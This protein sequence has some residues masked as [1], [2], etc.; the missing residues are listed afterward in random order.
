MHRNREESRERYPASKLLRSFEQ[1]LADDSIR[2][3]VVNTPV[4]THF[5]FCK[6]ALN[7]G[8]AVVVEKPFTVTLDEAK[9]LAAISKSVNPE[10]IVYQNRRYDG[11]Y[12]AVKK[13]VEQQLLGELKEVEIRFDRYRPHY[14]GKPHKEGELPGAGILHDL[15]AHMIDQALQLFGL[16]LAVFAD[17]RILRQNEVKAND[18]FELLLFYP[19]LRVR[20]KSTVIARES[21]PAYILHGMKGSF[22][23]QR[24][25]MQEEQLLAGKIPMIESWCPKP[26]KPDGLLHTE[27]DGKVIREERIS[28]AGNYMGFY[29][30]VY[31]FLNGQSG[32]PVPAT[33]AVKTMSIIDAAIKSQDQSRIIE[34]EL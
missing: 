25:D 5:D 22:L 10:F 9:E 17:I 8:K 14:S 33:D 4:Q 15:G 30:D 28:D 18:Y 26:V 11:D 16:P 1:L 19:R 21:Y 32:N 20:I 31:K 7:A 27:I 12:L 23:Q 29:D 13:V 34:L 2:L 3:I 24:T 6:A